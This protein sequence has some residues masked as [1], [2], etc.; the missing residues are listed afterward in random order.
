MLTES[1][2]FSQL[3]DSL[4]KAEGCCRQLAHWRGDPGW[5]QLAAMYAG[6]QKKVLALAARRGGLQ[7]LYLMPAGRNQPH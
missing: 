2:I 6:Q 5:L 3:Q 4:K 1:E 7:S